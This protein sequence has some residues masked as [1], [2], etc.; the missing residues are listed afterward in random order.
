M[1]HKLCVRQAKYSFGAS[2]VEYLRHAISAEGDSTDSKKIDVVKR[3][4]IP[5]N[6]KELT[7]FQ[8][9]AGYYRRFIKHYG[10]IGKPLTDQLKKDRFQWFE[11][12]FIAFEKLKK[13]LT[14]TP[15]LALA[16]NSAIFH[17]RNKSIGL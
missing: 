8:G 5:N 10:I 13:E 11:K 2:R 14:S 6:V 17:C 12:A 9:L 1:K 7:G 4:P 16:E 3:W 15:V